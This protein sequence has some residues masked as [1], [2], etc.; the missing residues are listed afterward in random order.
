MWQNIKSEGSTCQNFTPFF[1]SFA[2]IPKC[3]RIEGH[4]SGALLQK[5]CAMSVN[6]VVTPITQPHFIFGSKVS[7]FLWNPQQ[8][9]S[10]QDVK[11]IKRYL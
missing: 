9:I 8:P 6:A 3:P 7:E 10:N 5:V 11:N 2:K 4:Y 1:C